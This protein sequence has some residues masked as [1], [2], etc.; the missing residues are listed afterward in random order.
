MPARL[1]TAVWRALPLPALTA[2]ALT[3]GLVAALV[4]APGASWPL[5]I[6]VIGLAAAC[7]WLLASLVRLASEEPWPLRGPAAPTLEELQRPRE[8]GEI[9][10]A[11]MFARSR[12]FDF[13]VRVRPVLRSIAAARLA[14]RRGIDLDAE[15]EAARRALG[16]EAFAALQPP[17]QPIDREAR[18]VGLAELK[19][20]VEALEGL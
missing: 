16:K 1:R 8:L 4:L 19:R 9:E 10:S 7:V 2:V 17:A 6:Y 5:R 14:M 15:P 11:I 13:Q 18:G 12:G 20:L 3:G